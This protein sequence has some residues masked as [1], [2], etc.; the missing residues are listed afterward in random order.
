MQPQAR[1]LSVE[2]DPRL[3]GLLRRIQDP[4]LIAH[5]GSAE[6]LAAILAAHRLGQADAVISGIPFSRSGAAAPNGCSRRSPKRSPPAGASSPI[7]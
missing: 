7:R 6:D 2:I 4:R 3:H 1:L 5:L